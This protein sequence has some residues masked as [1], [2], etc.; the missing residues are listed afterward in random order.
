LPTALFN[1][2]PVWS[3][4]HSLSLTLCCA[5]AL[6]PFTPRHIAFAASIGRLL[7]GF[8]LG[9]G[10]NSAEMFGALADDID[11]PAGH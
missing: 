11:A 8:L 10:F 9:G 4:P 2:A 7:D 5:S 1:L 6:V 3:A